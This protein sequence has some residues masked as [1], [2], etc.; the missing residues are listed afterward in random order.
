MYWWTGSLAVLVLLTILLEVGGGE[1]LRNS[2]ICKKTWL[3]EVVGGLGAVH[4]LLESGGGD[5]AEPYK[6][7][8]L[9]EVAGGIG[10]VHELAG[11]L[12]AI[13]DLFEFGGG[14]D[15]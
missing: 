11:G 5:V 8:W 4:D 13:H 7:I 14:G 2:V 12:R 3:D 6:N 10:A 9:D 1:G 15:T